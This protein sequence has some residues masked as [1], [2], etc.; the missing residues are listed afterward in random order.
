M[1]SRYADFVGEVFGFDHGSRLRELPLPDP[2]APIP[3][4]ELQAQ[5]FAGEFGRDFTSP[6]GETIEVVQFGHWNRGAGPDFTEAAVKVDGE[7]RRG[8]I[9]VDLE[10]TSWEGHGHGEN[11]AFDEVV[12]HVF[13]GKFDAEAPR[14]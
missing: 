9:E 5:W 6:D 1:S 7:L 8:A 2:S 4:L 12:L 3:E 11:P 13:L 10:A 14:F